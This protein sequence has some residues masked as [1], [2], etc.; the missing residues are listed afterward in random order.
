MKAWTTAALVAALLMCGGPVGA[1]AGQA[2]KPGTTGTQKAPQPAKPP[3]PPP[4]PGSREPGR[5]GSW[6][7]SALALW[8]GPGALGTR[9]ATLT[10]NQTGSAPRYTLFKSSGELASTPG[11]A[12]TVGYHLTRMF[13]LEGEFSY[14]P[15]PVRISITGDVENSEGS[16]F[17]GETL[18]QYSM[19]GSV[20][21]DL[22]PL[23][24]SR[25]RGRTFV[26][27]GAAYRREVH[28][29]NLTIDTGQVYHAGGGVK[30][31][32]K[33]RPRGLVRAFGIRAEARVLFGVGGYSFDD[34][35][36]RN[37]VV[38]GGVIVA[39]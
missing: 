10:P 12:A 32:F 14:A 38:R 21:A 33:P 23:A 27:A 36:T 22:R 15:P 6:D 28:A 16:S 13:T 17:D 1:R 31:F 25:G 29:G 18:A 3:A 4:K 24:F 19:G 5:R 11:F 2:T 7:V 39:F 26:A 34:R 37:V 35:A 8:V 30:Y 9:D 20:V